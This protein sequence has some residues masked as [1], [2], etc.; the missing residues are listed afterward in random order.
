MLVTIVGSWPTNSVDELPLTPVTLNLDRR[1][2]VM[3]LSLGA[4]MMFAPE[5]TSTF[6]DALVVPFTTEIERLPSRDSGGT[7]TSRS[8][9]ARSGSAPSMS[10]E[11]TSEMNIINID[12]AYRIFHIPLR[13]FPMDTAVGATHST[14]RVLAGRMKV[15]IQLSIL[16]VF[17]LAPGSAVEIVGWAGGASFSHS[18]QRSLVSRGGGGFPVTSEGSFTVVVSRC[19]TSRVPRSRRHRFPSSRGGGG[20]TVGASLQWSA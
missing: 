4:S 13:F 1:T 5:S 15:L 12:S 16:R 18:P 3:L 20:T 8:P 19:Q 6:R 14:A 17:L 9:G 11:P 7:S 10:S 2:F